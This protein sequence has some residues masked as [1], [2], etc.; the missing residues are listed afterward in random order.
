MQV[1][2]KHPQVLNEPAP[3][4]F[5]M[6]F[7]ESSLDFEL[8]FWLDDPLLN[9][10]ITSE[11]GCLIQEIFDKNGIEIPYPQQDL[12]IRSDENNLPSQV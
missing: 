2:Q 4:A 6:G 3:Q 12:H 1:A 9:L 10:S 8:K 7:G 5:F 11:L